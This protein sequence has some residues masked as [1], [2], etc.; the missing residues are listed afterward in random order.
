QYLL[1]D[2]WNVLFSGSKGIVGN[3]LYWQKFNPSL[4]GRG[5]YNQIIAEGNGCRDT[6]IIYVYPRANIQKDTTVCIADNPFQLMNSAGAGVFSG[7]GVVNASG[8]FSP[9]L[10]GVGTHNIFFTQIGKCTDTIRITV[11]ALPVAVLSGLLNN[12]CLRDTAIPITIS[13]KGGVLTGQGISDTVFNPKHA[14]TGSHTITYRIGT[15]RCVNQASL[16]IDVNDTLRLSLDVDKDTICIGTPVTFSTK[17]SG[18]LGAYNLKWSG[19]EFNVQNIYTFPKQTIT[20]RAVLRDGCSDSVVRQAT[21]YVHPPMFG[22]VSTSAIQ[23]YGN[24][25]TA[26]L[27][28]AGPGPYSYLWNTIP[29]QTSSSITANVGTTYKVKVTNTKTG[30]TYDTFATIPGHPRIRAYFAVSP[31][32]QCIYSNNPAIQIIDLSE[33]GINGYWDFGDG[34]RETYQAGTNPSHTYPGDTDEYT[35]RLVISNNGGCTDSFNVSIC[36]LDTVALFI[37]TSFTPNDDGTND[38]FK[39]ESGNVSA[40]FIQIYNRWGE[41]VFDTDQPREGWDGTYR[42]ALCPND[43]YVYVIRY[44]GKKTAWR[45]VRGYLY[46]IR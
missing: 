38:V 34:S 29:A 26:T 18:G 20:Y 3:S 37:P 39:I 10:A 8:L 42:G 16:N 24:K 5:T 6:Q 33:G 36:V 31:S 35:I 13:P 14:G 41:K 21:V 9:S 28:M 19:G 12:Y 45:Y 15:G 11:N 25:G 40:A 27:T 43:Y 2:P 32:G 17:S 23:C 1:I 44:K 22:Q 7:K 4:A 46:L 30:C